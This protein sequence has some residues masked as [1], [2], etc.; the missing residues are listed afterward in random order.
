MAGENDELIASFVAESN[1]HLADIENQLMEMEEGGADAD[2]DLVNTIFRAI[3]STKGTAGFLGLTSIGALAHEAENILNLV[4]NHELVPTSAVV[5]VLLRAVDLLRS[6]VNDV[7]TSNDVDVSALCAELVAAVKTEGAPDV[8]EELDREVDI[9]LPTGELTFVM[10][11][12]RELIP[13]QRQGCHIYV[14]KA[15]L[16]ADV[17]RNGLNPIQ[18]LN[19]LYELGELVDSYASTMGMGDLS[20]AMPE[21]LILVM[22]VGSKATPEELSEKL[23]IPLESIFHI[24][25]PE[26]TQ[27]GKTEEPSAPTAPTPPPAAEPARPPQAQAEPTPT[28]TPAPVPAKPK[29]AAKKPDKPA[30][31]AARQET[32]LRVHVEVLDKLMNLAGELVLGRNQLLQLI[33]DTDSRGME[34]VAARLDQVTSELQEAIMQTRMQAVGTVFNRFVRIVRDLS[35]QLDKQCSLTIDGKQVE[36]DKAIIEAIGDPLTHLIRNS[37]DHGVELPDERVAKGKDPTGMIHLS[38]FH[39]GGKVNITIRDDGAGIDGSRLREKAV[40]KGIL[41]AEQAASMSEREAVRLIFHPGFSMAKT[42]TSVSGRGV[43]MDV[44]KTNIEKLG[45]IVDIETELGTGTTINIKLPLTL[46][47]IPSMIVRSGDERFAIPQVNISELVRIKAS[48]VLQKI[49]R[50]KD[51]EVLRLRG[52]L[53]PLVRLNRVLNAPS[54]YFDPIPEALKDNHR[55]NIADRRCPESE[56]S[57]GEDASRLQEARREDT[58]PGALNIIVVEAGSLRYG[59]IV[60]ALHDSEEIV[61]KPLG[62]HM[63]SCTCLAGATILG[64]GTVALILDVA[65]IAAHMQLAAPEADDDAGRSDQREFSEDAQSL[66]LFT[67]HPEE[68][69]GVPMELISRIERIHTDQLD[70]VGGQEVLQYRGASLPVLSLENLIQAKPR[71]D[72]DKLFVVAF[73]VAG[74]E[75]GLIA[76]CLDDIKSIPA[77]F[78][79]ATF[80][81]PGILGSAIV[82]SNTMRVIDLVELTF[83][84]H[85]DWFEEEQAEE[86]SEGGVPTILLAEDSTFFRTQMASFLESSNYEVVG[87]E[88]GLVAWNTLHDSDQRFDLVVTDIE[89]PNMDGLELTRKIKGD[90]SFAHLPIVAVTSLASEDDIQRGMEAGVNDYQIKMDREKLMGAVARLLKEVRQNAGAQAKPGPVG[91]GRSI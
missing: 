79:T 21:S 33:S 4:R 17:Q 89:M 69:F 51:A 80:R 61:V 15:D 2:P 68:Q 41:T 22:L 82:D 55:I 5:D 7:A 32:S 9:L 72:L 1:E 85:A 44:V 60:D 84:A 23:H 10:M 54:K 45:G 35:T 48:E 88:D 56:E 76:P 78:D 11:S 66:L 14:L 29:A 75:V 13:R 86:T 30:P 65:G 74:R 6:M 62:R 46:A 90:P 8:Q 47:I 3:H 58:T 42:V 83:K 37:V 71:P 26:E 27:W 16:I 19:Q 77:D 20:Q 50:V 12:I 39:Q 64:D 59:L 31:S 43:G 81:E 67:N 87:C 91:A 40:E 53:L 70:S 57:T 73:R 34:A 24:A 18:F 49:E 36:L 38:A 63:K 52:S 28:P 25:S